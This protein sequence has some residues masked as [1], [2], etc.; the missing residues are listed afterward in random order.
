LTESIKTV[1]IIDDEQIIRESFAYYFE[2]RLWHCVMAESGE[3]A[4]KILDETSPHCAIV[5]IRMGG[6]D[7]NSFIREAYLKKPRMACVICTGSPEY[8]IPD[9]VRNLPNVSKLVFNKPVRKMSEL[10]QE[11]LRLL[12]GIEKEGA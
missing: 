10:E 8:D 12:E 1:L 11:L 7:G 6:M 3:E 5:D 9:D 2:D 4:L